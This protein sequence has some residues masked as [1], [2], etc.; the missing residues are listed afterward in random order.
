MLSQIIN[1]AKQELGE[2]V[3]QGTPLNSEQAK[4]TIEIGGNTLFEGVKDQ[5]MAG[6]FSQ[7]MSIFSGGVN[8]ASTMQNPIISGIASTFIQRLVTQLGVPQQTAVTVVNFVLPHLLS[9]LHG[10]VGQGGNPQDLLQMFSGATSNSTTKP[11]NSMA[12]EAMSD[13][14]DMLGGF[15]K[16]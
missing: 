10:K 14:Q 3:T 7:L 2:T 4:E 8:S 1:M 13:I 6:N 16:K 5:V 9:F 12:G 11:N 15:F